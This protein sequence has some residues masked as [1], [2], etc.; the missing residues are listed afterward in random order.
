MGV[1]FNKSDEKMKDIVDILITDAQGISL[2]GNRISKK[3]L[4]HEVN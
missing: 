3:E 4:I 2:F 1:I